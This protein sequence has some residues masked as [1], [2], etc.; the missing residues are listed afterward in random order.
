MVPRLDPRAE[1]S[2][3]YRKPRAFISKKGEAILI[4]TLDEKTCQGLIAMYL[5]F[6][7]RNSFQGLPPV[8]DA[9]CTQWVQHMIGHGINI[10][11]LSFGEGVVGHAA[12][13]PMDHEVCEMFVVVSPPFQN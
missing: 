5:A 11:A 10:V 7:P 6:Q 4:R 1:E 13:F 12:L 8:L 3:I 9:A 2:T